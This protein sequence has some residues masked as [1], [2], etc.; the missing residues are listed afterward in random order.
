[1]GEQ[2]R[3]PASYFPSIERTYGRA[4]AE[5]KAALRASGRSG[6]TDMVAWLKSEHG[7][8][9]G[10]AAA[11]V[12]HT[13]H[14]GEARLTTDEAIA[15][16][17]AGRKQ[18]WRAVFDRIVDA[19]EIAGGP[20]SRSPKSSCVGLGER[21]QF[22]LIFP[23]TPDRLDVGLRL[24]G[25]APTDRLEAAGSWSSQMTHRVRV[26][27]V[28]EVDEELLAWILTARDQPI[29]ANRRLSSSVVA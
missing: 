18:H 19:V 29:P 20:V 11:L 25:H 14:E 10:H 28:Q 9:H 13:L 5:W 2:V 1:M 7:F 6:F 4:I 24:P 27:S 22:A 3:G 8:G 15:R 23:S 17:F 12:Q 16:L 26:R 21:P